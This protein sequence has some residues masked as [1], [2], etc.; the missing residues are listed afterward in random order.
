MKEDSKGTPVGLTKDVG[1]EIG[2]RRTVGASPDRVWALVTSPEGLAAWLGEV[3]ELEAGAS[4]TLPDGT[5]GEVRV[6]KPGS[7]LRLTWR[8]KGWA[9]PSTLQLRVLRGAGG[10][11]VIAFHQEHLPGPDEREGRRAFFAG[12]ADALERLLGEDAA[13]RG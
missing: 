7:H 9:R 3:T 1:W 6:L 2:L 10:R 4:Y 8:P 12:A 11:G 13:E 5:T